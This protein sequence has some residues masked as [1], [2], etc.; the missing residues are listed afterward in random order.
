MIED[1]GK[2][3]AQCHWIK[4]RFKNRKSDQVQVIPKLVKLFREMRPDVVHT[5]LF[6]DSLAGLTAARLAGIKMR[7]ITKGDAAFHYYHT[8]KWVK[9][10]RLNNWNATHVIAISEQNRKFILEKE[11]AN[12]D[13]VIM[14]HHGIPIDEITRQ[15]EKQKEAFIKRFQL[16]GK[17]VV[18]TVSR[19]I[20]WKG[21][22]FIIL[23][24]EEILKTYPDTVFLFTGI[25]DQE[26]KLKQLIADKG[27]ENHFRFT[28]SINYADM[29]SLYGIMDV[30]LHA[31]SF[32]P[33][34]FV[35]IEAMANGIPVISSATG[36]AADAI[37]HRK[38]G[39]L[40]G[41]GDVSGIVEGLKYLFENDH[42][43]IAHEARKTAEA[44][45]RFDIM[46]NNYISLYRK[47]L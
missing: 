43:I 3:G 1:V 27:L 24:A 31:A 6:D 41:Q 34:G 20:E 4:Y 44:L 9:F 7:V 35:I 33:F 18:G 10:D 39:V 2:W 46:W 11:H 5:H 47:S 37:I 13:K 28:G 29:P 23:A 30:Y 19:F 21:H 36:V 25:G 42:S 38:N 22:R 8:P 15:S 16:E 45:F 17:R 12:P 32:E 26:M 40:T 14:I